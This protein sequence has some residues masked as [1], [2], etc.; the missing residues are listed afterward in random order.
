LFDN[1]LAFTKFNKNAHQRKQL[2][3]SVFLFQRRDLKLC[4]GENL[5]NFPAKITFKIMFSPK[6]AFGINSDEQRTTFKLGEAPSHNF[7]P[8]DGTTK[9]SGSLIEKLTAIFQYGDFLFKLDGNILLVDVKVESFDQLLLFA[10]SANNTLPAIYS[11]RFQTY[12]SISSFMIKTDVGL[13]GFIINSTQTDPSITITTRQDNIR[14]VKDGC[15]QWLDLTYGH[16][17]LVFAMNYYRQAIRLS[18]LEL[19]PRSLFGEIILNLSKSLEILFHDSTETDK[20]VDKALRS[21]L[22]NDFIQSKLKPIIL[23]RN[24]IGSGHSMTAPLTTDQ[25][26]DIRTYQ[27]NA[28]NNVQFT[29]DHVWNAIQTGKYKLGNSSDKLDK[30]RKDLLDRISKYNIES[31]KTP[32]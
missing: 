12:I 21:G 14:H 10:D 23:L 27:M 7:N 29:I 28:F 24:K 19:N 25:M 1:K 22:T 32:L 20:F 4:E 16:E 9:S 26:N 17:R 18:L 5:T 8:N 15:K 2:Q 30:E 6:D 31:N 13:Y 3:M 11:F